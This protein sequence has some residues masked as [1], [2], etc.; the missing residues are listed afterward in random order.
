[1]KKMYLCK[2]NRINEICIKKT[3]NQSFPGG[4]KGSTGVA[5]ILHVAGRG[6]GGLRALGFL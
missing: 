2:I 6:G 1:M 3:H 4:R 5:T